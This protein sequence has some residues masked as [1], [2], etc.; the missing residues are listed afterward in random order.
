MA[1]GYETDAG[2]GGTYHVPTYARLGQGGLFVPARARA[3]SDEGAGCRV[4]IYAGTGTH[5]VINAI[6]AHG[7]ECIVV[8][9]AAEAARLGFTHLVLLGGSDIGTGL[10]GQARRNAGA[11]DKAR[12]HVEWIL[13]RRALAERLPT[14]GICRGHQMLAAASGGSLW[15]DIAQDM[16]VQHAS[17]THTIR[18]YGPLAKRLGHGRAHTVNSY[19]HQAVSAVPYGFDVAAEAPDGVVEAIWRPGALGVQWHPELMDSTTQLDSLLRWLFVG[20]S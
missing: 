1:N 2:E 18:A 12:D 8:Q 19:H 13:V 15:Q 10:Y 11:P 20:L 3:R 5:T 16:G 7:G 6:E 17:S 9:S 14:F 4:A